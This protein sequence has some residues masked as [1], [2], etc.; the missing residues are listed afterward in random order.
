MPPGDTFQGL[1]SALTINSHYGSKGA[2]YAF[3]LASC[4]HIS[5]PQ[6]S[7]TGLRQS[8]TPTSLSPQSLC[9]DVCPPGHFSNPSLARF[10][11]WALLK[12]LLPVSASPILELISFLPTPLVL[13]I[14]LWSLFDLQHLTIKFCRNLGPLCSWL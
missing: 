3:L 8:H 13:P 11:W 14:L 9:L 10:T 12:L 5:H 6:P 7:H 2:A 4:F 1:L